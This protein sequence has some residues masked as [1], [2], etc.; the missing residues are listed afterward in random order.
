[1]ALAGETELFE[2]LRARADAAESRDDLRTAEALLQEA[3]TVALAAGNGVGTSACRLNLVWMANQQGR[4]GEAD[5]LLA[6]NLPFVRARGQIRC[7][8]YT[9]AGIADTSIRRGHLP[10]A[11]APALLGATRALQIHDKSLAASCLELVAVAAAA[12]GDQQRAAAILAAADAA[13]H[14][15]GAEPDPDEQA[16]REQ[17]LKLLDQHGQNFVLGRAEGQALEL[18]AALSLAESAGLTQ[19]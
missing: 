15:M 5:D 8:G 11:A 17:A 1:M 6:E 4:H 7:E 9:L 10:E 13:R 3:L 14:A 2:S 19:V 18:P 16:V 12:A